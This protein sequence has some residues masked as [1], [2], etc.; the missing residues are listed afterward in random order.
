MRAAQATTK[1]PRKVVLEKNR[2][3]KE[4]TSGPY[5][6]VQDECY[7]LAVRLRPTLR[8]SHLFVAG[9]VT[10]GL[11]IAVTS[12]AMV[13]YGAAMLTGVALS[14]ALTR[15]SVSRARAAGF[16][17]LWTTGDS[18]ERA[19]RGLEIVLT[20]ELRN[21][22]TLPT[23]FR[24][25]E[26]SHCPTLEVTCSP[27]S[28]EVP[29]GGRLKLELRVRPLRVGYHGI[30][31]ITLQTIRAPGLYTVPLSFSN[32]FVLEVLPRAA[33]VG[34]A[35]AIGGRAETLSPVSRRGRRRGD[36]S[37]LRE[38]REHRPGDP[39]RHIAWKPSARRGKLLIIEME[40]EQ[41]DVVW[42]V[43]D[44]SVDSASGIP[45]KTALD[46]AIDEVAS[47]L[48][49]HLARGDHV[50]LCIMGTRRLAIHKPGRGPKHA[51]KMLASLT[52][53]AHTADADRSDWDDIDVARRV[54]E[55]ASSIHADA[56]QLRP[57]E[58]DKLAELA[59]KL[60]NHAPAR[61]EAPW[62]HSQSDRILRKYLLAFGIQPP[63]RGT[64]DRHH[65]ER[66][67]ANFLAEL[68]GSR[69]APA[70]VYL[71]GR[72][73]TFETPKQLFD[74]LKKI[75]RRRTELRFVPCLES[76]ALERE[77]LVRTDVKSH[78]VRDALTYRQ[79][80]AA[81]DGMAQLAQLGV[82]FAPRKLTKRAPFRE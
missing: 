55:H 42:L 48:E 37:E 11:G 68:V 53:D 2:P 8:A 47:T 25:L 31:N 51:A 35:G 73:P 33:R 63:P 6:L 40:Q 69:K 49:A 19:T 81:E 44:A 54:F 39:Y 32:P 45:G 16:E 59:Q 36:G 38:I 64:S 56:A 30:H 27:S 7:G 71:F 58:H 50:G 24:N 76:T 60:M 80:M 70:L 34:L 23:R 3:K 79:R 14:R 57:Y 17:M 78:L 22:D 72:P 5:Q 15:V 9:A 10:T 62:S 12:P 67:I 43:I 26:V 29:P 75:T 18:L 74:A 52:L 13:A 28:G 61:P 41:S 4:G 20:A 65:V 1:P 82:K 66:E 77:G 21:R 46:Y